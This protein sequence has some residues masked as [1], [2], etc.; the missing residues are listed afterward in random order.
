MYLTENSLFDL[1]KRQYF[2]KLKAYN[3]FA[4]LLSVHVIAFLLSVNGV[5]SIG[6]HYDDLSISLTTYSNDMFLMLTGIWIFIAGTQFVSKKQRDSDFSF[7]ST[8]YSSALSS[9]AMLATVACVSGIA[10]YALGIALK[11]VV[12]LFKNDEVMSMVGFYQPLG[13]MVLGMFVSVVYMLLAV[14]LGYAAGMLVQWHK[15][16]AVI[17]PVAVLGNVF[18]KGQVNQIETAW[19]V[20][21]TQFFVAETSLAM[22]VIKAAVVCLALFAASVLIAGKLEV[23]R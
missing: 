14:G 11:V 22:F 8:P 16:F 17:L 3:L 21:G 5:G 12:V 13:E 20:Q 1:V 18:Y 7:P 23:R 15:I 19:I 10:T 4:G 6:T 2:F 9:V